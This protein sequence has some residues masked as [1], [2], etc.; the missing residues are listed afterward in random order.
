MSPTPFSHSTPFI[1]FS[2]LPISLFLCATL[3]TVSFILLVNHPIPQIQIRATRSYMMMLTTLNSQRYNGIETDPIVLV[4]I[5]T[6]S[7]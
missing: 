1:P 5:I 3:N 2:F 4:Q 6:L 7:R